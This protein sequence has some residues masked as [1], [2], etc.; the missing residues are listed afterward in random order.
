MLINTSDRLTASDIKNLAV[1][2]A[3]S[4]DS[5]MRMVG[6]RKI[7]AAQATQIASTVELNAAQ[8]AFL[9]KMRAIDMAL[10][11][12]NG[13]TKMNLQMQKLYMSLKSIGGGM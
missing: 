3:I 10:T 6:T 1:S 13:F 9:V 2:K 5:V 7:T 4:A 12:S 11:S 8:T